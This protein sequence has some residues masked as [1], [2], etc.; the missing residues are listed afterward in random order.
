MW[1]TSPRGAGL[2][3]F[4]SFT[5]TWV[6]IWIVIIRLIEDI[7]GLTKP[8]STNL[9]MVH[10]IHLHINVNIVLYHSIPHLVSNDTTT[11]IIKI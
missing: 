3:V 5:N 6:T 10:N 2:R 9:S 1:E 7:V 11:G 4:N 8:V